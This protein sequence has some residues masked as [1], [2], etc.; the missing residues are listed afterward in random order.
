MKS[1]RFNFI[2]NNKRTTANLNKY[3]STLLIAHFESENDDQPLLAACKL[4]QDYL[5]TGLHQDPE[6][7]KLGLNP[8]LNAFVTHWLK[9][10]GA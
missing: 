4:C 1:L 5:D 2:L 3:L 10:G 7:I 6:H 8:D 9:L